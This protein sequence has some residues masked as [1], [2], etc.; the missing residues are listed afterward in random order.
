ME[1]LNKKS[2]RNSFLPPILNYLLMISVINTKSFI[3]FKLANRIT[4]N[5]LYEILQNFINIFNIYQQK[6]KIQ[7]TKNKE[8]DNAIDKDLEEHIKEVLNK[9]N[10][11]QLIYDSYKGDLSKLNKFDYNTNI[12]QQLKNNQAFNTNKININ[13]EAK[14]SKDEKKQ[15][16]KNTKE[17]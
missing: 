10:S 16:L 17:K 9:I 13:Q 2:I 6:K 12:L 15:K 3:E 7:K 4:I 5:K 11:Y 1:H 14:N 8:K